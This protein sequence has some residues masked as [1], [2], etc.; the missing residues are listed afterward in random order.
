MAYKGIMRLEGLDD[1]AADMG[2]DVDG[3]NGAGAIETEMA[4][5]FVD[6]PEASMAEVA[7]AGN[8]IDTIEAGMDKAEV[9][10]EQLEEIND[11]LDAVVAEDGGLT[12]AGAGVVEASLEGLRISVGF[13]PRAKRMTF[14]GF[15]DKAKRPELTHYVQ[16]G[17]K[18]TLRAIWVGLV[19][20]FQQAIAAIKR[21]FAAMF[22]GAERL[23]QRA[24]KLVALSK[25]KVGLKAKADAK[26]K[27]N[28]KVLNVGGATVTG[29][30]F[31]SS[32]EKSNASLE[33]AKQTAYFSNCKNVTDKASALIGEIGNKEKFDTMFETLLED[34]V[35]MY[36]P[37][38][39]R[40]LV[41]GQ[42][43]TAVEPVENMFGKKVKVSFRQ[44]EGAKE[45]KNAEVEPLT[46]ADA[47]KVAV[48]ASDH[49]NE[50]K[51]MKETNT[52]VTAM[53]DKL[54]AAAKS[55]VSASSKVEDAE[56]GKRATHISQAIRL[57]VNAMTSY[58]A[59]ERRYDLGIQSAALD[60]VAVSLKALE[61]EANAKDA[62]LALANT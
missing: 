33:V 51:R 21:F 2:V 43:E 14:E 26:V 22:D 6:G 52:M 60:Y 34:T 44:I 10:V 55:A 49:L 24:Q 19:N 12:E 47:L 53:L 8:E 16:E 30:T 28:T 58:P 48:A 25:A 18:E 59:T 32:F 37:M 39:K 50:Y 23:S 41:F 45:V 62:S 46:V 42:M 13:A 5:D 38:H 20:A 61:G 36:E 11:G 57:M 9:V 3:V 40:A 4:A 7:E 35:K 31:A 54:T 29:S 15:K 27:Q 17:I 56:V 1:T